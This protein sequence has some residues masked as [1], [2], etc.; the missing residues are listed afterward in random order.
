MAARSARCTPAKVVTQRFTLF[1]LVLTF[2]VPWLLLTYFSQELKEE[3]VVKETKKHLW[4]GK[5][6]W[7]IAFVKSRRRCCRRW[8]NMPRSTRTI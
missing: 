1:L 8:R 3:V 2:L 7:S 6:R 4:A 5:R